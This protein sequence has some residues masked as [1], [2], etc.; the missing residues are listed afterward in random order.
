[1]SGKFDQLL[2]WTHYRVLI[3]LHDKEAREW[4]ANEAASETWSVR[5]LQRNISTQYYYCLLQTQKKDLVKEEMLKKTV[6]L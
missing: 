5:T 1:M 2:S 3:Q 4:Y 6:S